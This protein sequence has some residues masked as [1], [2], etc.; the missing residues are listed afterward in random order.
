MPESTHTSASRPE[1]EV[2]PTILSSEWVGG[3]RRSTIRRAD[4][5]T[6][7]VTVPLLG[8]DECSDDVDW[9]RHWIADDGERQDAPGLL[10]LHQAVL[11]GVP[12][13]SLTEAPR[14]GQDAR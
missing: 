5:S 11:V 6:F 12:E 9:P 3:E 8:M 2:R 1:P 13:Q 14:A 7:A 10:R 4:G